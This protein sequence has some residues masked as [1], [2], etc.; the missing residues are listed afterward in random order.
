MATTLSIFIKKFININSTL[1]WKSS[2]STMIL[3][4]IM[5]RQNDGNDDVIPCHHCIDFLLETFSK[6]VWFTAHKTI[7]D[8]I[9]SKPDWLTA[10]FVHCRLEDRKLTHNLRKEVRNDSLT[11]LQRKLE[12]KKA[13]RLREQEM[14]K[15][16]ITKKSSQRTL[17]LINDKVCVKV[18][19]K[20]IKVNSYEFN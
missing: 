6:I 19:L 10:V 4:S 15:I 2:Q 17:A 20:W 14:T 11:D 3:S 7:F 13:A 18:T 16:K 1:T 9:S 8:D 12:E 5:T